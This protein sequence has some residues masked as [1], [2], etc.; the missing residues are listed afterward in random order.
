MRLTETR[1]H[2][3]IG[4]PPTHWNWME[5]LPLQ[6][7]SLLPRRPPRTE[8]RIESSLLRSGS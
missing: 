5:S 7:V 4:D 8:W 6:T 1:P 3:T 2:S